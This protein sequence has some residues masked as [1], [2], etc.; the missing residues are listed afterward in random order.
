[1][2]EVTDQEKV[3]TIIIVIQSKQVRPVY[4]YLEKMYTDVQFRPYANV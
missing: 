1:M 3:K 2:V 4:L